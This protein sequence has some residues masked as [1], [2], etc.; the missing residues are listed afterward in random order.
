M[1]NL[2]CR[3]PVGGVQALKYV[4][5]AN[6]YMQHLLGI[7]SWTAVQEIIWWIFVYLFYEGLLHTWVCLYLCVLVCICLCLNLC[8]CVCARAHACACVSVCVGKKKNYRSP[9]TATMGRVQRALVDSHWHLGLP[10]CASSVP[11][12]SLE[13]LYLHST[14]KIWCPQQCCSLIIIM[15]IF[16]ERFSMWNMLNCAEQVQK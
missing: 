7:C 10:I 14:L 11:S 9:D 4:L 12:Q 15:S 16:L 3:G 13:A 1:S 5:Q 2:K 8:T 6:I